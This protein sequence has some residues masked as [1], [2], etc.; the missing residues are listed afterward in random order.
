MKQEEEVRTT[1]LFQEL[2]DISQGR[3]SYQT[4]LNERKS[5]K[6]NHFVERFFG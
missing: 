3:K 1:V 5:E 2:E 6:N 4:F